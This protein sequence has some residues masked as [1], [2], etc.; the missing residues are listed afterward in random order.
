M[1]HQRVYSPSLSLSL[2]LSL[3]SSALQPGPGPGQDV[4][5][6]ADGGCCA[7]CAAGHAVVHCPP[8]LHGARTPGGGRQRPHHSDHRVSRRSH[9][10]RQ[11]GPRVTVRGGGGQ[12]GGRRRAR[13]RVGTKGCC[14]CCWCA[15]RSTTLPPSQAS[16][17]TVVSHRGGRERGLVVVIVTVTATAAATAAPAN[18]AGD[19]APCQPFLHRR[20]GHAARQAPPGLGRPSTPRP[21]A[22]DQP[23]RAGLGQDAGRGLGDGGGWG[24]GGQDGG[25]PG[26]E[27]RGGRGAEAGGVERRW[28]GRGWADD[29]SITHPCPSNHPLPAEEAG[30]GVGGGEEVGGG[31]GRQVGG[32]FRVRRPGRRRPFSAGRG[33]PGGHQETVEVYVSGRWAGGAHGHVGI[34]CV[35]EDARERRR[36]KASGEEVVLSLLQEE[37]RAFFWGGRHPSPA[38]TTTHS[39]RPISFA[40]SLPCA[41]KARVFCLPSPPRTCSPSTRA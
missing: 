31:E 5:P 39:S 3:A 9:G 14:C 30:E 6:H 40:T 11:D 22:Q 35:C 19:L 13:G 2:S 24:G 28:R 32:T 1:F 8:A 17:R 4:W 37:Q 12:G 26:R 21:L 7:Q 16:L 27:G 23:S 36:K 20:P 33:R 10:S 38:P 25:R 34:V 41:C 18:T 15:A 29:S